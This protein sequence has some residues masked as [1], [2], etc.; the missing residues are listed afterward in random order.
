MVTFLLALA[1]LI[2]GIFLIA[3]IEAT[4]SDEYDHPV[5]TMTRVIFIFLWPIFS[6]VMLLILA[7]ERL[8]RVVDF[9]VSGIVNLIRRAFI[10]RKGE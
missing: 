2:V 1:Y 10:K 3:L 4:T 9:I 7:L 5:G 8:G 6:G